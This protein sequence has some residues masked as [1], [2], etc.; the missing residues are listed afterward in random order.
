[1]MSLSVHGT[2][3]S[4]ELFTQDGRNDDPQVGGDWL[5]ESSQEFFTTLDSFEMMG[6]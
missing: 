2:L 3:D 1:M 5:G 6:I 4:V